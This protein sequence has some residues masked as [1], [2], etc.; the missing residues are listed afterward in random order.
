MRAV[1]SYTGR[2]KYV[3]PTTVRNTAMAKMAD[4]LQCLA[5][6]SSARLQ[7]REWLSTAWPK[8]EGDGSCSA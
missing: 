5:R 2:V 8:M 3:T 1:A 7:S 4:S 6:I